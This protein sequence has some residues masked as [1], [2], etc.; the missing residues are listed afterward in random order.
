M[1]QHRQTVAMVL[2]YMYINRNVQ[3]AAFCNNM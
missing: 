3:N 2:K 1:M